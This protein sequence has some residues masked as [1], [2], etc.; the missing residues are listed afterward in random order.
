VVA[1]LCDGLVSLGHDVT[2]FAAGPSSTKAKCVE[3]IPAPLRVRMN[4]QEM[5][6]LAPHIHLRML[7]DVYDR[8]D[9]FDI[10][11]SHVDL[12]TLPFADRSIATSLLTLHGRLDLDHVRQTLAMYPYVPL[13]AISEHH[14]HSLRDVHVRWA[15]TVH[16]GLILD[17]Y[18]VVERN[19]EGHLAFIGRINPEKGPALAVEIARRVARPL[20]VAAKIDPLDVDYYREEIDPL[21]RANDVQFIG[22]IDETS[23]PDFYARAAC[24]L[25]PIDWP[26]P[27]GL[28]MIESMA[29]GTPVV[30]LRRGSVPEIVIDGETGFVCDDVDQMVGAIARLG[31]IDP[32]RCRQHAASFSATRMSQAYID[33]Y[34]SLDERDAFA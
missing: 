9:D 25:F 16:N 30:A 8:A 21:F 2:L 14:R 18:H 27:F 20:V 12:W 11:H 33:V 32:A 15:G 1:A 31:E 4:R 22:E 26:E 7:A 19:D 6:D 28:V 29:A 5:L 23:K 3:V 10:I 34:E 17:H 13:A 24:T